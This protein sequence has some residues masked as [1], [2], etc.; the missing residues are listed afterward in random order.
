MTGIRFADV[1]LTVD[2]TVTDSTAAPVSV[3]FIKA[4][5]SIHTR[6]RKANAS[7]FTSYPFVANG[8]STF[9]SSSSSLCTCC[10]VFARIGKTEIDFFT[11]FSLE[12]LS[13]C[14]FKS[15]SFIDSSARASVSAGVWMTFVLFFA[16]LS[17]ES[18]CACALVPL[19]YVITSAPV[20]TGTGLTLTSQFTV[21][22]HKSW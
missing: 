22:S 15:F 14:T 19:S 13:T 10:T 9:V 16:V 3:C 7:F 17:S 18:L 2:T 4:G 21:R 6:I 8:T 5:S 12:A 20:L 11:V 1:M